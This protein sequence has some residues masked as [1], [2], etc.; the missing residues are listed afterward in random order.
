MAFRLGSAMAENRRVACKLK[1][2]LNEIRGSDCLA[3]FGILF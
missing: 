3:R 2:V 1:G